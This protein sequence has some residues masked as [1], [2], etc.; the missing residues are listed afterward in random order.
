MSNPPS[1]K[2]LNHLK[3]PTNSLRASV[4][5]YTQ[6]LP[7]TLLPEYNHYTAS[8]Q[9]YAQILSHKPSNTLL[10]LRYAPLQAATQKGWDPVTWGVGTK[11]DLERWASWCDAKGIKRSRVLMGVKSWVLGLQDPDGRIVR[12]FVE[13]EEHAWTD[14]PDEDSEWLG[15]VVADPEGG[16]TQ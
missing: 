6:I 10:E 12:L 8:H 2:G 14:H 11:E 9:I 5:F 7:F 3:L 15:L 13:D 1:I 16:A 4:E